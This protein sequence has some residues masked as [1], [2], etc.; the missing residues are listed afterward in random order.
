MSLLEIRGLGFP[1]RAI[2]ASNSQFHLQILAAGTYLTTAL[3]LEML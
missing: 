2:R 3:L 1:I